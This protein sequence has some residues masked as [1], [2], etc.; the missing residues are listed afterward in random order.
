[1][2]VWSP[3][4]TLDKIERLAITAALKFYQGNKQ[5]TATM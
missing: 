4:M 2:F 1:M 3:G 5:V